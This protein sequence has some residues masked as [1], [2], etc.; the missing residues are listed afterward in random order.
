MELDFRKQKVLKAV[1]E[2]YT[3]TG[4]PVGS[5]RISQLLDI[6]VSPAT[7][8][9]DMA[10]LFE[11]GMLEQPYT[12]AGRVPSHMGY[13]Y[14]IDHLM[15]QEPLSQ[16]QQAEIQAMFNVMNPDPDR[17]LADAAAMLAQRTGCAAIAATSTPDAVRVQRI[18]LIPA[19][20]RTVIIMVIASNG[21]IKSRVCRVMFQVTP[22]VC[23]FFTS[24]ANSR[25]EGRTLQEISQSYINSVAF[26]LGEYSQM[27]TSL[28][29]SIYDLCQEIYGGQFYTKG[30]VN[31][32]RQPEMKDEAGDLLLLLADKHRV[33]EL[34][35]HGP[36]A[37][38]ITVGKENSRPEL[39]TAAVA[40]A[41]FDIGGSRC[42]SIGLV[43]PVRL[44]Y[45]NLVPYLDY[46]AKTLGELLGSTFQQS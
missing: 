41:R 22:N 14:Y 11:M 32:L 25:L 26:A 40:F 44:P 13:R 38:H 15:Q 28:L 5:K 37:I 4:E 21:V 39:S 10:A 20:P 16:M 43:G 33:L 27:F 24:F 46:F 2:E 6:S 35:P 18:E 42:G 8:R 30:E 29:A 3:L 1:I 23:E 45:S 12:S 34:L 17:L 19:A 9:N 7:I 36:G 31:L